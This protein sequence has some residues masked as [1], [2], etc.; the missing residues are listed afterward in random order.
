MTVFRKKKEKEKMSRGCAHPHVL[1]VRYDYYPTQNTGQLISPFSHILLASPVKP[2]LASLTLLQ[3]TN[4]NLNRRNFVI[5]GNTV[6]MHIFLGDL[7]R[8]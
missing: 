2:Y 5:L 3:S 7:K 4:C 1:T 8:E 6:T